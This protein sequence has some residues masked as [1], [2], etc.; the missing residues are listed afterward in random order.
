[1]RKRIARTLYASTALLSL[2]GFLAL[3]T[4]R[5]Y[6][7]PYGFMGILLLILTPLGEG[8]DRRYARYRRISKL[9][10]FAYFCFIPLSVTLQGLLDAVIQ[11]IMFIEAF[12][13]LHA[14]E[15]RNY[16]HIAMMS[17][18]LLIAACV[19]SPEPEIAVVLVLFL[20]SAV[21]MF[22]SLRIS[23]EVEGLRD[24]ALA[25]L[26][27]LGSG[28]TRGATDSA[29]PFDGRLA[30]FVMGV[31]LLSVLLTATVFV[32]TPRIEAGFLGRGNFSAPRTGVDSSVRLFSG[33][34]ILENRGIVMHVEFPEEPPGGI[35]AESMYW[36]C[37]S[38]PQLSGEQWRRFRLENTE[39]PDLKTGANHEAEHLFYA[40]SD[41][42]RRKPR[43]GKRLVRQRIYMDEVPADGVPCLDLVQRVYLS[44]EPRN[45]AL[46]W[47]E[48]RDFTVQLQ[49]S[50]TRRLS[51]EAWS[52]LD[53]PSAEELRADVCDYANTVASNDLKLLTHQ[54]LSPQTCALAKS[55]TQD[56]ATVYDKA[57][58]IQRFLSGPDF[59]YT[60]N[61]PALPKAGAVD[62]FINKTRSGHCEL[63]A[64]AMA[65]MLRS[66]GVPTRVV[67][68]YRGG[69]WSALDGGFVVRASMAHL[70]VEVLFPCYGWVRFDPAPHAKEELTAAQRVANVVG[71]YILRAK[72]FWYQS[73]VG[74]DKAMQWSGLR[75]ATLGLFRALRPDQPGGGAGGG[76]FSAPYWPVSLGLLSGSSGILLFAWS[77]SRNK[78][79]LPLTREQRRAV[80]LH[81]WMC[82]TLRRFAIDTRG[83]TPDELH[84]AAL[85]KM[86]GA[87]GAIEE[88]LR[89]YAE[90]RFGGR[91]FPPE[92]YAA[93]R[94]MLRTLRPRR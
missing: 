8:M 70:W 3:G 15:E 27:V 24:D 30:L 14:K 10:S 67:S 6:G 89:V 66:V 13:M 75:N 20:V 85:G 33:G 49:S 29:N 40:R 12:T 47:D 36:R 78:K 69:E 55:L 51:Y 71:L 58:A 93:I 77:R 61:V 86:E 84:L 44:G 79:S 25:E 63:F 31:L 37:T 65:L 17:F 9:V 7:A 35:D 21:W 2:A 43:E 46:G 11:L 53:K 82:R 19:Q 32:S 22:V 90:A 34:R 94:R 26:T 91:A 59:L 88:A 50:A 4:V 42:V 54:E 68:G 83:K 73:V 87:Q 72:M 57:T 38:M 81:G 92:R 56:G 60:M 18:F 76:D 39:E 80:E 1:M 52:E 16:Y 28:R 48:N 64:S 23:V 74:Y 62:A 41:E 5:E 45:M